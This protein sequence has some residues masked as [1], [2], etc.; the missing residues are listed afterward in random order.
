MLVPYDTNGRILPLDRPNQIKVY[1]NYRLPWFGLQANAA[2][3]SYRMEDMI[4]TRRKE[5]QVPCNWKIYVENAME[6]F[7]V[8]H[9]HRA[10]I[11]RQRGSV[12]NDRTFDSTKGNWVVMHKEHEGSRAILNWV[13]VLPAFQGRGLGRRAVTKAVGNTEQRGGA[14]HV[15]RNRKVAAHLLAG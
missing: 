6:A 1:G 13:C 3:Q 7:H 14:A 12:Q 15:D 8:P 2:F 5:Y 10:S 11:N 9:V 4:C